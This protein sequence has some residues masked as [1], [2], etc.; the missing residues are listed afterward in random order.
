MVKH[1]SKDLF[2]FILFSLKDN[3]QGVD[4]VYYQ[5]TKEGKKEY[6]RE[7]KKPYAFFMESKT[8]EY[9]RQRKCTLIQKGSNLDDKNY[10]IGM[11]KG[12]LIIYFN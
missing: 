3:D 5:T 7:G 4:K 8:I 12:T 11:R 2:E 10:G 9:V 1:V 6:E